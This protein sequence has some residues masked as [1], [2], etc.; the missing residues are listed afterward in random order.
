LAAHDFGDVREGDTLRHAFAISNA[1]GAPVRIADIQRSP[2]CRA[3]RAPDGPIAPGAEVT[4]EIECDSR[5]RPPT[6]ADIVVVT[7][8]EGGAPL[9]LE[10]GASIQPALAFEPALATVE[11]QPG[12]RATRIVR[13]AG[14]AA[15][16]ATLRVT[17]SGR[18]KGLVARGLPAGDPRGPGIALELDGR[19][20]GEWSDRVVVATGIEG[21]PPLSLPYTARVESAIAVEPMKPYFNLRDPDGRSRTLAVTSRRPGF[22]LL[23]AKVVSGPFRAAIEGGRVRVTVEETGIPPGQ[24]GSMGTLRIATN[25]AHEPHKEIQLFAFGAVDPGAAGRARPAL[26]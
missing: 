18:A 24:R 6:L 14:W 7:P 1:G 8:G 9:R 19:T 21:R 10:L 13:V 12:Q 26:R 2:A 3:L 23:G 15:G 16:Q 22:R 17:D 25:D 20:V 4:V 5:N 11:T